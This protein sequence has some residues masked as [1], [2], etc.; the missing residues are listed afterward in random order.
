MFLSISGVLVYVNIS[1]QDK[2][3]LLNNF[4]LCLGFLCAH[5]I[6]SVNSTCVFGSP[7]KHIYYMKNSVYFTITDTV[8]I[9]I[10]AK[11]RTNFVY[12]RTMFVC[13][14]SYAERAYAV[15]TSPIH[16]CECIWCRFTM[17]DDVCV[18]HVILQCWT[19]TIFICFRRKR[20]FAIL[21]CTQSTH[22]CALTWQSW[23]YI[24]QYNFFRLFGQ[25]HQPHRIDIYSCI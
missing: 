3:N 12:T 4:Q 17:V 2:T 15:V 1:N 23:F 21:N 8:Q 11:C 25:L 19:I 13:C 9:N 14:I 22:I 10:F 24:L 18:L 5:I 16:F 6:H 20:K 7:S